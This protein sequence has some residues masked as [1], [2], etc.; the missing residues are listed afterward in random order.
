MIIEN[1]AEI[2]PEFLYLTYLTYLCYNT[3]FEI[4]VLSLSMKA[5]DPHLPSNAE[6]VGFMLHCIPQLLYKDHYVP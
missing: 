4:S 5:M 1:Q 2:T 3:A 6:A